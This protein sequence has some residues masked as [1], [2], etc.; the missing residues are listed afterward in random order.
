MNWKLS[1]VVD[2]SAWDQRFRLPVTW[3]CFRPPLSTR[4]LCMGYA[5]AGL[6]VRANV[7]GQVPTILAFPGKSGESAAW[8]RAWTEP[9]RL[10]CGHGR[11]S[12]PPESIDKSARKAC[13][14]PCQGVEL[15]ADALSSLDKAIRVSGRSRR[16]TGRDTQGSRSASHQITAIEEP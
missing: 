6:P 16:A 13:Q 1:R 12:I 11:L 5:E 15:R 9:R 4:T 7:P 2:L 8:D 10:G 3:R 14:R